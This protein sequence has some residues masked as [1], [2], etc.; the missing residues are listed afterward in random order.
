MDNLKISTRLWVMIAV[1]SAILAIVG[2]VGLRGLSQTSDS[3]KTVYEDRV[4]PLGQLESVSR[5]FLRNR[6]LVENMVIIPTPANIE[7]RDTELVINIALITKTW[8][9]Y[10][11]THLTPEEK[12]LSDEF[13]LLIAPFVKEGLLP[14]RDAMREGK[15]EVAL[16]IYKE[17]VSTMAPAI[18]E[19]LGKLIQLQ[20]DVSKVEN[21]ESVARYKATRIV[22]MLSILGGILFAVIFGLLLVRG[23]SR[24]LTQAIEATEAVA[25]GDLRHPIVASGRNEISDLM[26]SLASMQAGLTKVVSVVLQGSEGVATASAQI[27]QGNHDLSSRT[28]SQASALEQTASSMEELGATVKQNADTAR[29][30]NQLAV[31]ASTVASSGGE[32]VGQMASTMSQINESSKKIADIIGVIDGIAFQTNILALNAAVEA[33]RAGEQGR[34][35]AVVASEVRTLAKRSADAAKEIKSLIGA[36]VEKVEQGTLLAEQARVTMSD[37]TASIKRVTDLMGEISAASTE[38][39]LGVSQVGEAV[40]Q[41]DQATQ[42]NAALVEEMAAAASSLKVQAEEL[43]HVVSVFKLK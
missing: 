32:V 23:I 37:V 2:F 36:S 38:Q 42:Q 34:G 33:A 20:L 35:F 15:Q 25:R 26:R 9:T 16:K 28:E 12:K 13:L 41:M 17:K 18:T 39:S 6:I 8:E 11:A 1:L 22:S 40:T 27:A 24:S 19:T 5:L 43:V 21:D 29:T 10:Q 3:L 14:L 30:A 4:L 7:K 31:S